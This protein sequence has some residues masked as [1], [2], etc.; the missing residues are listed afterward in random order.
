MKISDHVGDLRYYMEF[1]KYS[2][3]SVKN[4]CSCLTSFFAWCENKGAFHPSRINSD[5]VIAFLKQYDRPNTHSGYHSAIKLYF[6]KVA[7]VGIEKFKYIE[8][9][10]K[11]K[12]LPIIIDNSDIQKLFNVC[13]NVKHKAIMLTFY[14]TGVRRSELLNIKISDIDSKRG[15]IR[16]IGKGNKERLVPLND[17]L[18]G[19]LRVYYKEYKPKVWLFENDETHQQYSAGSIKEFMNKYKKLAGITSPVTPH[20][21]RHSSATMLLEQGTDLR[22]IQELLGHSSSKTT[23]IYTHVSK[24]I[25]SKIKSPIN[26]LQ[27]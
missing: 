23:E 19:Y 1:R 11:E 21:F 16:I 8:R 10:K 5:M 3:E 4:Y 2:S 14:A 12:R 7:K 25:I 9:P 24:N 6:E 17:V 13:K 20:K 27:I 22:I 26:Y 18:L 15:V